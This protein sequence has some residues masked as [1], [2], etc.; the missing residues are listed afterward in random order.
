MIDGGDNVEFKL[1]VGGGL[2]DA[3]VDFDL[4]DTWAV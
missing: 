1:A 2:E 4:L 3:G